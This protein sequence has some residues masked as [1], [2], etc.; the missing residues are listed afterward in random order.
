[1]ST[2]AD[3]S[4][5]ASLYITDTHSA[6]AETLVASKAPLWLTWLQ[7]AEWVHAVEQHVFRKKMSRGEADLFHARF[8]EHRRT[9]IWVDVALPDT[10]FDLCAQLARRHV[11]RLGNR[12]LDTLHVAAALELKAERFWTFDERQAK[13]AR[14]AGLKTR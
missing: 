14:A 3:T 10:T 1:L 9:G 13:L 12:I 6:E 5:L 2:Y 4:F 7:V 8:E 11:A